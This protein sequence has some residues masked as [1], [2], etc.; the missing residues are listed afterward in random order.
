MTE[1]DRVAELE[2]TVAELEATVRGLTEEL[3]DANERLRQLE[4]AVD[5]AESRGERGSTGGSDSIGGIENESIDPDLVPGMSAAAAHTGRDATVLT[6]S[7]RDRPSGQDDDVTAGF[8]DNGGDT[9]ARSADRAPQGAGAPSAGSTTSN[10]DPAV[11]GGS[12]DD[13]DDTGEFDDEDW[14]WSIGPDDEPESVDDGGSTDEIGRTTD[15]GNR[16]TEGDTGED[17]E[18]AAEEDGDDIIVA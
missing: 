18:D 6:Q 10:D 16:P 2:R 5:D 4:N 13:P 15:D 3:V 11:Y 9:T 8:N 14:P 1:G 12:S 7:N 17:S